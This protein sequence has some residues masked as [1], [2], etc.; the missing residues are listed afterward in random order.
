MKE[1]DMEARLHDYYST[2]TPDDSGRAVAGVGRVVAD[3]RERAAWTLGAWLGRWRLRGAVVVAATAV[4]ALALAAPLWF[5]SITGP[6]ATASA[7]SPPPSPSASSSP[8]APAVTPSPVAV[9]PG[10]T[11][12]PAKCESFPETISYSAVGWRGSRVVVLAEHFIGCG[13]RQELLS[14][15]PAVGQWRTDYPLADTFG[16]WLTDGSSLSLAIG[17]G[18]LVVDSAGKP[19]SISGNFGGYSLS[20]LPGGGYLVVGAD[21]LYRIASDGSRATSDA[22]PAGYVA[23]AP[24]SDPSLFMLATAEEAN[25][26]YGLTGRSPFRAYLWNLRT[27]RVKLVASDV[28]SVERSPNSLAYLNVVVDSAWST[29]TLAADG[30]TKPVARPIAAGISPDGSHYVYSSDPTAVGEVTLQMRLTSMNQVL[31]EFTGYN[32]GIVWSGNTAALASG[33]RPDEVTGAG[34]GQEKLVIL[35]GADVRSVPLP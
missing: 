5:G 7:T 32:G 29:L 26:A 2:F 4:L 23:V 20:V 33:P 3:A 24:T 15:D 28:S 12:G 17:D 18:F 1:I 16:D 19:H 8:T 27:G 6:A 9:V 34:A 10:P 22:L 30:S 13:L 11:L 21:K 31:S 25:T 35:D 14:V